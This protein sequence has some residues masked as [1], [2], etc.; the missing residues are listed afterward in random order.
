VQLV[1]EIVELNMPGA[2]SIQFANPGVDAA[3]PRGQLLHPVLAV[4]L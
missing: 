4:R 2:Q 1:E 3:F